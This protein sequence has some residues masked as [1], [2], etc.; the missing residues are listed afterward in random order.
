MTAGDERWR[1]Q[2]C[3]NCA[4]ALTGPFCAECGQKWRVLDLSLRELTRSGWST[5]SSL[6]WRFART[7][8]DLATGPGDMVRRWADGQRVRYTSPFRF[9]FIGTALWFLAHAV[10]TDVEDVRKLAGDTG[11]VLHRY[12]QAL[13]LSLIPALALALHAAFLGS[14]TR[15]L[16]HL[17]LSL[18][19]FGAVFLFRALL[20]VVAN[21]ASIPSLAA[22][23]ADQL[24]FTVLFCWGVATFHRALRPTWQR[25][26]RTALAF[27]LVAIVSGVLVELVK[28]AIEVSAASGG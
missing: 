21:L 10:F 28:K 1:G 25:I 7:V 9:A 6:D 3:G 26:A 18:Y 17:C 20:V 11:V 5:V 27:F 4:Q 15:Y 16:A 8:K 13:N 23:I 12:G 24:F 14:R 2:A 19:L 22:S